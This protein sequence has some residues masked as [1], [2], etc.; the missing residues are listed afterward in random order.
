[1]NC[2][3]PITWILP[4]IYAIVIGKIIPDMSLGGSNILVEISI[5]RSYSEAYT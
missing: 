5:N 2:I 3:A 1:M 4:F